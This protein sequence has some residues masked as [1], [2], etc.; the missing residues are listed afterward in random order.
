MSIKKNI[1]ILGLGWLGK[2]LAQALIDYGYNLKGSYSQNSSLDK[3]DEFNFLKYKIQV[4]NTEI[5]GDWNSFICDTDIL[6][7]NIPPKKTV[8]GLC[9]FHLKINQIIN[10]LPSCCSVIFISSTSVY[11][12]LEGIITENCTPNPVTETARSLF[13]SECLLKD[14]LG[15]KLL[16]LRLAG[17]IGET[18]NPGQFLAGRKMVKNPK[19]VVNFVHQFDVIQIIKHFCKVGF[20]GEIYNICSDEHPER[21]MYYK[22]AARKLNVLEP[23]FDSSSKSIIRKI[24]NSKLKNRLTYRFKRNLL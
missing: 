10:K 8:E 15:E 21:E 18:R 2:P 11:G 20:N 19:G 24:D 12:S 23:E 22:L 17:L 13:K 14:K 4:D 7:V 1:S 5:R 3:L 9:D 6:I 16:I